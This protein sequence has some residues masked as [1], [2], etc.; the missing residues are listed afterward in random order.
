VIIGIDVHKHRHTAAL[1]DERGVLIATLGFDN[2]PDGVAALRQW[3]VA[4][5]AADAVVGVENAGGY[6]Q[7]VSAALAAAGHEVL[8]VPAWRTKRDRPHGGPGKS[9]PGDALAIAR[10]VL[11]ERAHLGPAL[12]PELIRAIGLLETH[13]RQSVWR[14]TDAVQRLRAIWTQV[15]PVAEAALG[16]ITSAR[17]LRRLKR[18]RFGDGL[19]DQAAARCIQ[20]LAAEIEQLNRRVRELDA[21]LAQL[22]ATHGNPFEGICGAGPQTVVTLIAQSGD[23]R[24]F[25][26]DAAYARFGG[27]APIP[28]GSGR[29]AGRHRL[30][31]GGNRQVNAALHRIAV[32]QARWDPAGKAFLARKIAEGKTPREARRA[33]KRH[34]ANVVYRRLRDWAERA[35]PA[36]T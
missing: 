23:V 13:R 9:D 18:I 36:P 15:D 2:G 16:N 33:L 6:G 20:E 1:I 28:C 26:S 27:T 5:Q 12:E 17:A 24:R 19:A 11:Q 34:L 22:V 30:H 35:L 25:R 29:T 3:L 4:H 21:E 7:L 14:R 8:N 31:R 32:T 10:V